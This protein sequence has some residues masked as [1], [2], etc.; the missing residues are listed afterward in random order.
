MGIIADLL[1]TA[2]GIDVT[3]DVTPLDRVVVRELN[4]I[5][6]RGDVELSSSLAVT[7]EVQ[8]IA[9]YAT[10][11]TGGTFTLTILLGNGETVT[12]GDIAYD[13]NAATIESAIDTAA[14]GSITGWTNGDISVSGGILT[15][16][17]VVLTYDGDSVAGANHAQVTLDGASLTGGGVLGAI[18]TTTSGQTDRP[19]WAAVVALGIVDS[20]EVPVQGVD[21]GILTVIGDPS[22]S[23]YPSKAT[24]R[25]VAAEA[26][27]EDGNVS[28]ETSILAAAR[29]V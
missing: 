28:T 27:I 20:A 11:F 5:I 21:P 4:E 2:K 15:A 1:A 17:P 10:D 14:S 7:D 18:T 3:D 26:A 23:G 29:L 24:I 19:A 22:N 25:A 9:D 13:A 6:N 8:S 12:T 16:N